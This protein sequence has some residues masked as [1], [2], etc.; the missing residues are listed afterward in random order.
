M[1]KFISLLLAFSLLQACVAYPKQIPD[2]DNRHCK[3]STKKYALAVNSDGLKVTISNGDPL[4][5]AVF[6]SIVFGTTTLV[7][8]SMVIMGNT[9]HYME[10]QSKC[11]DSFLNAQVLKH[12]ESLLEM[13][14]EL[15]DV[16]MKEAAEDSPKA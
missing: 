3:L 1:K 13:G 14:G 9:L 8:G 4:G 6:G 12:V 11:E 16:D 7:S 15:I 10:A 2:D 5:V